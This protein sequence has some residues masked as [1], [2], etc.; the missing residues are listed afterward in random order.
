MGN[1]RQIKN[2]PLSRVTKAASV[3]AVLAMGAALAPSAAAAPLYPTPD[4]DSFYAA[5]DDLASAQ[6]GDVLR[7]RALPPLP[8]FPDVAVSQILF[9]STNSQGQPIA[10]N[11]TIMQPADWQPSNPLL[12]YQHIING[13]GTQCLVANQLY[14]DDPNLTIREAPALNAVLQKGWTVALPDHLGPTMA[15]GAAKLGGQITLDGVRAAQRAG[16]LGLADSP[17][18]MAGY[19]GGGMATAW[20]AALAP[21]YAPELDIA[22]VAE[23]GVPMNLR[24]MGEA[25]GTD[26]HPA[27]GL[28]MAAAIG[29]ERE[30]PDRLPV[31]EELNAEG[32]ALRDSMGNGCTNDIIGSGAGRSAAQVAKNTSFLQNPDY[33]KILEENSLEHYAGVPTA[34]VYEWHSPTDAL[35]PLDSI[36]ATIRRYCE[37]GA[38][39][40][41]DKTP[42]PEHM[43]A[44]VLGLPS[45]FNYLEGRFRGEAAPSNC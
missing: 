15:Y 24:K 32:I 22:G 8:L 16:D 2:R 21:E 42:S 35:I 19:S 6:P 1:S 30:Y 25:L 23:G 9:R 44:A 28:A 27:F 13:L 5:P 4:P 38:T 43:S 33:R 3:A 14:T 20:A 17:V 12:S 40:Q 11:T 18:G 29:L 34:P 37:A 31:S 26:P 7:T 36:D 41:A 45:A 39:V 10:A